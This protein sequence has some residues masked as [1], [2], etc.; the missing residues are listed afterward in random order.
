MGNGALPNLL[1]TPDH[2]RALAKEAR[3]MAG[4]IQDPQSRRSLLV[5]AAHY[6]IIAMRAEAKLASIPLPPTEEQ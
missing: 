6:E 2:W 5:V 4:Q 1:A 3:D